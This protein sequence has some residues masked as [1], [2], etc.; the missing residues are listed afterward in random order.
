M[1]ALLV[2][3]TGLMCGVVGRN[4]SGLFG[5]GVRVFIKDYGTPLVSL[6]YFLIFSL[7]CNLGR[8]RLGF[9]FLK[10]IIKFGISS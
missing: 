10:R 9:R 8:I 7:S 5:H 1:V 6:F 4:E 3:G 2:L